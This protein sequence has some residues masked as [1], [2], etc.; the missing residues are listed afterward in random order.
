MS[1]MLGEPRTPYR[2]P[3]HPTFCCQRCGGLL[4]QAGGCVCP[5]PLGPLVY[6]PL[7]PDMD[8]R[9]VRLSGREETGCRLS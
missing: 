6:R 3:R 5:W 4:T 8:L 9:A 1:E 2:P 7:T